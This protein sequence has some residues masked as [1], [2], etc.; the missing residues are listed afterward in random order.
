MK[1]FGSGWGPIQALKKKTCKVD[2]KQIAK[3][4]PK[5]VGAWVCCFSWFVF[6]KFAKESR[7]NGRWGV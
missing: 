7:L 6:W 2:R 1:D 5:G 3:A 4:R